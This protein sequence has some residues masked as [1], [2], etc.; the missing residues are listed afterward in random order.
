MHLARIVNSG[1]SEGGLT[2]PVLLQPE[3]ISSLEI[4]TNRPAICRTAENW[5]QEHNGR[6][7]RKREWIDPSGVKRGREETR[8]RMI[9]KQKESKKEAAAL[10]LKFEVEQLGRAR[11]HNYSR[12]SVRRR[13]PR[14]RPSS[15]LAVDSTIPCSAPAE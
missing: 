2:F 3:E 9:D 13:R 10:H 4:G 6:S 7:E 11:A 5:V 1:S 15:F 8:E 12:P 14:W